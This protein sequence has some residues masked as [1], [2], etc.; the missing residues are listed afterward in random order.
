M[1]RP[2][3]QQGNVVTQKMIDQLKPGMTREQVAFVMGQ[4]VIQNTF[5]AN[6]WDYVYTRK[7]RGIQRSSTT[8][9]LFF[10]DDRLSFFV[11]HLAPRDST[12]QG[13]AESTN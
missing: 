6:R 4:P 3:M 10:A 2:S 13:S 11:G 1:H 7:I 12:R 5:N 9:S 8:V